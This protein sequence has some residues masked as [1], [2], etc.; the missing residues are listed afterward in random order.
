MFCY[1]DLLQ[2][3]SVTSRNGI[4]ISEN[5]NY[6]QLTAWSGVLLQ[7]LSGLHYY[8]TFQKQ[9]SHYRIQKSLPNTVSIT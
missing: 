4:F 3:A 6:K 5:K 1:Q 7:K 8:E 9:K 2:I